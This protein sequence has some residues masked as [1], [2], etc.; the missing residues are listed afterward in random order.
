MQTI[1]N[2]NT[3]YKPILYGGMETINVV[4]NT[5]INK[6]DKI[7]V[8]ANKA[9]VKI[10]PKSTTL[11]NAKKAVNYSVMGESFKDVYFSF[12]GEYDVIELKSRAEIEAFRFFGAQATINLDVVIQYYTNVSSYINTESQPLLSDS[13]SGSDGSYLMSRSPEIG[14]YQ[15]IYG[16]SDVLRIFNNELA[17]RF[18]SEEEED[19]YLDFLDCF[20][21]DVSL[22]FT[23]S[24][25][26]VDPVFIFHIRKKG[27]NRVLASD[28]LSLAVWG[29]GNIIVRI[30]GASVF[31]YNEGSAGVKFRFDVI[32]TSIKF[33]ANNILKYSGTNTTIHWEG[34]TRLVCAYNYNLEDQLFSSLVVRPL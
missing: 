3:T 1:I 29:G 24:S 7:P 8:L 11:T 2:P 16:N 30:G 33:Y 19:V 27:L 6:L 10:D 21:R 17:F 28:C 31:T 22:E 13:F 18:I 23:V 20:L 34:S 14:G 4:N 9:I 25:A 12:L 15:V 32:G 26:M 5:T